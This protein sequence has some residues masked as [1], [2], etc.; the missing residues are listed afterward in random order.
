MV[1]QFNDQIVNEVD[2]GQKLTDRPKSGS[3]GFQDHALPL[4]L[5][6]IRIR[7]LKS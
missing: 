4:A 3:I 2:L 7:E 1:V 6:R 5:R